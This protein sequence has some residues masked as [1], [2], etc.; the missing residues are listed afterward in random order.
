VLCLF[1]VIIDVNAATTTSPASKKCGKT[2]PNAALRGA[3][4]RFVT[5][6]R[7]TTPRPRSTT[8]DGLPPL[9]QVVGGER[10][11]P[12]S[13]P[14]IVSV[15]RG[16]GKGKRHFCG[17]T[18]I[19]VN[20]NIDETDIVITASH[21]NEEGWTP[22]LIQIVAGAHDLNKPDDQVQAVEASVF[23][24]HENYDPE[25]MTNDIAIL[26]LAKPIKFTESV[27]P[28][29]LP[30][31]GQRFP[32][33]EYRLVAGWGLTQEAN[34]SSAAAILQ[35]LHV[36]IIDNKLC[37]DYY[38]KAEQP[39]TLDDKIQICA[40]FKEGGKDA[41]QG[42]SGGPLFYNNRDGYQLEAVVSYGEGCARKGLPGIYTLVS[43]YIDWI[44]KKVHE[45]S[46]IASKSDQ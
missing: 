19:R 41:C 10:A 1:Y 40:G 3:N 23:E 7:P 18:L 30:V 46:D 4:K 22:N 26:K 24:V 5:T 34:E 8:S 21:C 37:N 39:T 2:N 6:K 16:F 36:P 28:A 38:A 35:Q 44:N 43:G 25:N 17:G 32:T 42:D 9:A 45:L 13:I 29:C 14:W 27:Q 33:N 12:H 15:Q 20:E 31:S 11:R